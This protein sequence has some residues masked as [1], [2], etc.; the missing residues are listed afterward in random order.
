MAGKIL[1]AVLNTQSSMAFKLPS[2][3]WEEKSIVG[4][5]PSFSV[6]WSSWQGG[7]EVLDVFTAKRSDGE[8]AKRVFPLRKLESLNCIATETSWKWKLFVKVLL[9]WC[10]SRFF[11]YFAPVGVEGRV[12]SLQDY[13]DFMSGKEEMIPSLICLH[14]EIPE[15]IALG[16]QYLHDQNIVHRD[17]KLGNVLVFNQHYCHSD[18]KRKIKENWARDQITCRLVDFRESRAALQQ[19]H[20]GNPVCVPIAFRRLSC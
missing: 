4:L 1:C 14:I 5:F 11:F 18:D 2:F 10:P 20:Y 15:D 16:V 3:G 8:S 9:P 7:E 6:E 12:S 13:F 19:W 17:I